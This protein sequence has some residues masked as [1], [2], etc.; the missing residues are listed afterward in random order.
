MIGWFDVSSIAS[1]S[2][3]VGRQVV[4]TG[5]VGMA[6]RGLRSRITSSPVACRTPQATASSRS[7]SVVQASIYAS[8]LKHV[9]S[10]GYGTSLR[11]AR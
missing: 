6:V 3:F 5:E 9:R 8:V 4:A 11:Y 10:T 2:G 1:A 7:F